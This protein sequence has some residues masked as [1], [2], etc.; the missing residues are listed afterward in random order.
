MAL[1]AQCSLIFQDEE[2]FKNF[3][4]E[5]KANKN[6]NSIIIKCLT[7][8]YYN[9]EVRNLVEDVKYEDVVDETVH[10]SNSQDI[11][12]SIRDVVA[13]QDYMLQEMQNTVQDGIEQMTDILDEAN[14]KA[15]EFGVVERSSSQ[16]SSSGQLQIRQIETRKDYVNQDSAQASQQ[17]ASGGIPSALT[18]QMQAMFEFMSMNPEFAKFM[19]SRGSQAQAEQPVVE[20]S[21]TT[22]V[23]SEVPL[24]ESSE[25]ASFDA[26]VL[27]AD[28]QPTE[29]MNP[30]V[31][32]DVSAKVGEADSALMELYESL[33]I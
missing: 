11:I 4:L 15:E 2:L 10:V 8:Y 16:F 26:A 3:I 5:E 18:E 28:T 24:D 12:N 31:E 14:K 25:M 7:A 32:E 9:P 23:E 27:G 1:R 33:G 6:L 17:Q 22:A 21:P 20:N 30:V 19:A 29:I 13:V